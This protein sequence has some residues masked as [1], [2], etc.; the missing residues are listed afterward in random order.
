MAD[1]KKILNTDEL[2]N[3]NGGLNNENGWYM[4]V[5][6][7]KNY[8][9][10]RPLPC[11][12]EKNELAQLYPGYQVFTYGEI[13]NGTGLNGVPCTYRKVCYNNIWGWANSANLY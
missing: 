10:L 6:V 8:L 3:A 4:T 5:S 12:D 9:A 13:T 2:S 11:W 1:E 7:Q